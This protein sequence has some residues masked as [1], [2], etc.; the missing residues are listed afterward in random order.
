MTSLHDG[1]EF[2]KTYIAEVY[3]DKY[4]LDSAF[5]KVFAD[6]FILRFNAKEYIEQGTEAA[7]ILLGPLIVD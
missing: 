1:K 2:A 6:A 7:K 4:S 3:G 5:H